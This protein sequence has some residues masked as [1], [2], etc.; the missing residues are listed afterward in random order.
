VGGSKKAA[1]PVSIF[2]DTPLLHPHVKIESVHPPTHRVEQV[3]M[4]NIENKGTGAGGANTNVNGK[5]FEK[6][7]EN[8]TRLLSAGF[9]CK[10]I[11][12]S[13]GKYGFYL[14]K[15]ITPTENI[16]YLTQ[17]GLKA[18]FAHFFQKEMCRSPDEAYL[19][20]NGES[21]TLK[22]LEKKNQNTA[23]SVDTKLLAGKGFIDEY[24]FLLGEKFKVQYAFC[25]S[26]FLKKDYIADSVKSKALRF[27]NEKYGIAVLYGDDANYYDTLDAWISSQ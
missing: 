1:T 16:T 4:S 24:E 25:I 21:Y 2:S 7:T 13:T 5:S 22:I 17:G 18:Y 11:P 6:K 9:I 14:V 19:F 27:I 15:E 8:E 23:G 20:R 26:A 10:T 12:G 3:D